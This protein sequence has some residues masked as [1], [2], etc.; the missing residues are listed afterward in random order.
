MKN[1]SEKDLIDRILIKLHLYVGFMEIANVDP[2]TIPVNT[3]ANQA[4]EEI[5]ENGITDK[6]AIKRILN[7]IISKLH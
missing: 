3:I 1:V 7:K 5:K 4:L 6:K 2:A